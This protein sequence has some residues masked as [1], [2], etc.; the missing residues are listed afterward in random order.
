MKNLKAAV[1]LPCILALAGARAENPPAKNKPEEGAL[2]TFT[3]GGVLHGSIA[4]CDKAGLHWQYPFAK[5]RPSFLSRPFP[6]S[7]FRPVG[8][9]PTRHR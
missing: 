2:L 6:T 1:L 8:F 7:R 5:N 4:G 3:N 9:L